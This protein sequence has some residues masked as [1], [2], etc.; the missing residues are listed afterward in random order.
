MSLFQGVFG[1]LR[2]GEGVC[3][4]AWRRSLVLGAGEVV[5][6]RGVGPGGWRPVSVDFSEMTRFDR[7]G[8]GKSVE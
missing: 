8:A 5:W 6:G 4:G 1:D 7:V 2:R 3:L